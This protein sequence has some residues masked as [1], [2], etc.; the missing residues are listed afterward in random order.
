MY[1]RRGRNEYDLAVKKFLEHGR[2]PGRRLKALRQAEEKAAEATEVK[3]LYEKHSSVIFFIFYSYFG[4]LESAILEKANRG[5]GYSEIHL[6]ELRETALPALERIIVYLPEL[7]HRRFQY[8][9]ICE[10]HTYCP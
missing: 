10:H 8:N 7:I 6:R 1:R 2:D 4:S 3:Q 5:R 9:S